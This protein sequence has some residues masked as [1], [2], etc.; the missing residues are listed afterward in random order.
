MRHATR[1]RVDGGRKSIWFMWACGPSST[2][3]TRHHCPRYSSPVALPD[4]RT[5]AL[6]P[7]VVMSVSHTV[8]ARTS[9]DLMREL[10]ASG[11]KHRHVPGK[12]PSR[13]PLADLWSIGGTWACRTFR[14]GGPSPSN[15][16]ACPLACRRQCSASADRLCR[17]SPLRRR[18]SEHDYRPS[19][20]ISIIGM[21][22]RSASWYAVDP[23]TS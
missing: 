14:T 7:S 3:H 5:L 22:R 10:P 13:D 2:Y 12:G 17:Q 8:T 19:G 6:R 1:T 18:G 20:S 11:D 9:T 4:I 21:P 15:R 23:A 16:K